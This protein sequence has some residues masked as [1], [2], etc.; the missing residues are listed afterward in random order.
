MPDNETTTTTPTPGTLAQLQALGL[1]DG[2]GDIYAA[3]MTTEDTNTSAPV[4]GDVDLIAEAVDFS[5]TRNYS[6]G[7]KSAS[8]RVIRKIKRLSTVD[9]S[10]TIPRMTPAMRQKYFGH[11]VD[12]NGGELI[13]DAL[14]PYCAIGL[15]ETRD[16]DTVLMRWLL[17]LRMNEGDVSAKTR[18]DGTIE[19]HDPTIEGSAVKL[20]YTWTDSSS[21]EWA[22]VEYIADT[23]DENCQ[24]TKATFFAAVR[25]PWS[26]VPTGTP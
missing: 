16:D 25:G 24:W 19:Y 22:I 20:S 10:A 3:L 5:L 21:H 18:E 11:A 15:C 26:T 14:A 4:Y 23:A 8:N 1:Y 6:E 7:T 17:K 9:F 2:V 12:T 13:A